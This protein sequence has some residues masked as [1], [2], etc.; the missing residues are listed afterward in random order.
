MLNN[1]IYNKAVKLLTIREHSKVEIISKL[2]NNGYQKEQILAVIAKL[3][4]QNL[5]SDSRFSDALISSSFNRGKGS[6]FI[7]QQLKQN[8]I[9]SYNL[10]SYDF[11]QLA[12]DVRIKKYGN[13]ATINYN[14]KA[15]QMRFLRSRGFS[16][17][18]I[19]FAIKS[20]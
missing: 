10:D 17:T 18:E 8:S 7:K 2:I 12:L 16:F 5:Q 11:C 4:Q 20:A 15:K 9:S 14:E 13:K 3:Q 6:L 1:D 19:E